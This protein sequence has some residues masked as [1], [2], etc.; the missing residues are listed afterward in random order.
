MRIF[1]YSFLKS[2]DIP[3]ETSALLLSVVKMTAER[4]ALIEKHPDIF[5]ELSKIAIIQSVISSN[6]IEGI[7]TTDKR[8]NDLLAGNVSPMNHNEREIIGY[9]DVLDFIHHRY[10]DLGVS[11]IQILGF[12]AQMLAYENPPFAGKY[13]SQDNVIMEIA[14]DGTRSI[15]FRPTS[16]KET[17][18]SMEQLILAYIDARDDSSI[19]R[20]LLIPCVILDF[21]CIHPFSD[22]NGRMS[23]LL[24]LLLLYKNDYIIGKY[25]S[26]E[27]QINLYKEE[28]YESLRLSSLN[29][30]ANQNEY[31]PFANNFLRTLIRCY[32]EIETRFNILAE[33]HIGKTDRIK[34]TVLRSMTPVSRKDI[35]LLWPDIAPDTIK[36]A[37]IQL[38]NEGI[39]KKIG[40]FR[41][42]KYVRNENTV[43]NLK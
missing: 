17:P 19:N 13:K 43:H 34:E 24:S 12:H 14:Y 32:K 22:G 4:N 38:Q 31:F 25:V 15:R 42:A 20:L 18:K 21:L 30:A 36:K 1:D 41:D 16:A 28:Y 8:I 37:L 6:E 33:K 2:R 11:E 10:P 9:K 29:W 39:I 40:S 27:N 35:E 23:R 5:N 3:A 7:V 26:F